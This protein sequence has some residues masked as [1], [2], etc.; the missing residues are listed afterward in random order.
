MQ[1]RY[2]RPD[3]SCV[4]GQ[5]PRLRHRFGRTL[6]A[7]MSAGHM[8]SG[9]T[10]RKFCRRRGAIPGLSRLRSAATPPWRKDPAAFHELG[11]VYFGTRMPWP[12]SSA[13][14]RGVPWRRR[15]APEIPGSP[16][17]GSRWPSVAPGMKQVPADRK[18][19]AKRGPG[20]R[21]VQARGPLRGWRVRPRRERCRRA[22]PSRLRRPP[23]EAGTVASRVR[24]RDRRRSLAHD[25][26]LFLLS[27]A[28]SPEFGQIGGLGL[29]LPER[30]GR[31]RGCEFKPPVFQLRGRPAALSQR[32]SEWCPARKA[33]QRPA[34]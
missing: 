7:P 17:G 29:L 5:P 1:T 31:I 12:L 23:S 15:M 18:H 4:R 14:M 10:V 21:P 11:H 22:C 26:H 19:A 20:A 6:T 28:P 25:L 30:L 9:S 3:P 32:W 2:R 27:A 16:A 34:P 24:G 8:R 13:C 33:A